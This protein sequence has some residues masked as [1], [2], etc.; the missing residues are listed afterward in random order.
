MSEKTKACNLSMDEITALIMCHAREMCEDNLED[1]LERLNYLNKRLKTFNE[2]EAVKPKS[3]MTN[4]VTDAISA[5]AEANPP[6][7]PGWGATA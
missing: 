5:A 1:S 4:T 3:T 2:P 6:A 7:S